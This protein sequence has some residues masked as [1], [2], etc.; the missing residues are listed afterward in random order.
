[1]VKKKLLRPG[2]KRYIKLPIKVIEDFGTGWVN[3]EIK[4]YSNQKPIT[5]YFQKR[6]LRKN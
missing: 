1:M 2:E 3:I 6:K 4:L 5:V